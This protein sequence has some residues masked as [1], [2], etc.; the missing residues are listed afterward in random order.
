MI[1]DL[2][3]LL[4]ENQS[5]FAGATRAALELVFPRVITATFDPADQ[6]AWDAL[7]A[8]L[9]TIGGIVICAPPAG[10]DPMR[11]MQVHFLGLRA[12]LTL[13]PEGPHGVFLSQHIDAGDDAPEWQAALQSARISTDAAIIDGIGMER[14]FR[15]NRL[16]LAPGA[17]RQSVSSA[18]RF[19]T[20]DR[21]AFMTGTEI[22][23]SDAVGGDSRLD[24][25]TIFVTGAT[26][27]LGRATCV[28]AARHGAFVAVGGRKPEEAQ[29]TLDMVR[30]AGGDGMC[31]P[32]D[33]TDKAQWQRAI[34]AI[35]GRRGSIDAL[36]NNAGETRNRRL[37]QLTL[38]DL[39]FLQSINVTGTMLGTAAV[40]PAMREHGGAIVNISSVAGIRGGPGGAAYSSTKAAVIG[41]SQARGRAMAGHGI[42]VNA[43]QPGL[44]WSDSVA[45]S[46]GEQGALDFRARIEPLTPLGRV[47]TPEECAKPLVWLLSDAARPV[48]GQAIN[49]SGGLELNIP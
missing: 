10:S 34:T 24:D 2:P 47:T 31:V 18:V 40:E 37:D 9:G 3:C 32:L 42:R 15:A 26:S 14:R 22:G 11:A 45:D 35:V 29:R 16:V 36:V 6:N 5:P 27:G 4:V 38:D 7:P 44:I 33:V 13:F 30:E 28:E 19:L 49:V 39:L 17:D 25:K 1:S 23:L 12:M 46:L 43:L 8:S 41:F 21:S 48:S 20:D